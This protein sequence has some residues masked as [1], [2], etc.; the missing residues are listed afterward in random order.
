[1]LKDDSFATLAT[2][3]T[4]QMGRF[5]LTAMA[6]SLL[7]RVIRHTGSSKHIYI[8]IEEDTVIIDRA[9]AALTIVTQDEG[10]TR[11][12]GVCTPTVF[13]HR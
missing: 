13:C 3:P 1:M 2:P 10:L 9:L 12:F 4:P 11:G 6:A 8:P 7:G 5:A